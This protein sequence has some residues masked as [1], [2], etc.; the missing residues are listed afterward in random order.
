LNLAANCLA[1]GCFLP[2]LLDADLLDADLRGADLE[3]DLADFVA[4]F[5]C[6]EDFAGGFADLAFKELAFADLCFPEFFF[7]DVPGA[8]AAAGFTADFCAED[9]CSGAFCALAFASFEPPTMAR[10]NPFT[11][12]SARLSPGFGR[13]TSFAAIFTPADLFAAAFTCFLELTVEPVLSPAQRRSSHFSGSR[14]PNR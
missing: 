3:E 14:D 9:F 11:N 13:A 2:D 8:F 7:A 12:P 1:L 5:L 4:G 10:K 6:D